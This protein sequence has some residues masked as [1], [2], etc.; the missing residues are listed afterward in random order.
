[1]KQTKQEM[2][3][4]YL[5]DKTVLY[6]KYHFALNTLLELPVALFPA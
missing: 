3:E 4:E 2:A 5:S 1:M 6:P